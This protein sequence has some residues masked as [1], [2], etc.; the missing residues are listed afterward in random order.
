MNHHQHVIP[1]LLVPI[2]LVT[3]CG[4]NNGNDPL[5]TQEWKEA[6]NVICAEVKA[7][8]DAIPTPQNLEEFTVASAQIIELDQQAIAE[9]EA[10]GLP[11]GDENAVAGEVVEA[12]TEFTAAREEVVNAEVEGSSLEELTPEAQAIADD[13][14]TALESANQLTQDFGL[15]DCLVE[16]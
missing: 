4:S 12:L 5:T 2:V 15:A 7:D 8:E 14:Q 11:E 9:L 1:K 6:A 10:L 16:P 3:G 13:F